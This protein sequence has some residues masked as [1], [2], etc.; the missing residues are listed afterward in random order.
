MKN[1]SPAEGKAVAEAET[2]LCRAM[3]AME[4]VEECRALLL[5]LCT[6]SELEAMADRWRVV[7]YLREGRPYREIHDQTGVSV[8]TIGRVCRFLDHGNGGYQT[9]Y[10]RLYPND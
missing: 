7:R 10:E 6:P 5:D 2:E 1:H 9:A 3:M 8:T 4:S